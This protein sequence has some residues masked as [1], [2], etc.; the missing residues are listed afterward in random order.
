M[1]L[2]RATSTSYGDDDGVDGVP[3]VL[4]FPHEARPSVAR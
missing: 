1:D 4:L 3:R 2:T